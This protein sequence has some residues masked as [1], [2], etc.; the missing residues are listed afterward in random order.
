VSKFYPVLLVFFAATIGVLVTVDLLFFLVFWE[1]MTL[2]S[3]FLVTFERE[4][5]A[6][7]RAGLKYFVITHAATLCMLAAVLLLWRQSGS[8]HFDAAREALGVMLAERPF[9]AHL[10]LLLLLIGFATKAGV[11]PM[12]DWLPD[13][14]P[15]A[16]SGMSAVLSG[17]LVK[18]G[19]Y[20]LVR[21]FC[22]FLPAA[23][24]R[25]GRDR[26]SRDGSLAVGTSPPRQQR[27]RLM[28]FCMSRSGASAWPGSAW[29][30]P[31]GSGGVVAWLR[32]CSASTTPAS[33]PASS[34]RRCVLCTGE[35][36]MDRLGGLWRRCR[37]PP[38]DHSR[39][40]SIAGVHHSTIREQRLIVC[41]ACSRGSSAAVPAARPGRAVSSRSPPG[42]LPRSSARS[43]GRDKPTGWCAVPAMSVPRSRS[44]R[45]VHLGVLPRLRWL[46]GRG[47]GARRGLS[48]PGRVLG[49]RSNLITLDGSTV[50]SWAPL[51]VLRRR[52]WPAWCGFCKPGGFRP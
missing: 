50:A 31:T 19:I 27:Q 14:H 38:L 26:V 48:L 22:G 18:L 20:G 42:L 28:A 16:P 33:R 49:G 21:V 34:R 23:R 11:L 47:R 24:L 36:D 45:C 32:R 51:P 30:P 37:R 46:I 8:F 9:T 15:V 40:R 3:F 17:A 4:S 13:A 52:C 6:S 44:P 7:Q 35:R 29:L 1:L 5:A 43:P 2:A 12:G 41:R 25:W 10:V 39:V